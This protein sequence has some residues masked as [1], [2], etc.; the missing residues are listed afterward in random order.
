MPFWGVLFLCPTGLLG[1][2]TAF[3]LFRFFDI[4]KPPPAC[5][6]DKIKNGFGVMTDDVFAAAMRCWSGIAEVHSGVKMANS[7]QAPEELGCRPDRHP[8]LL[9]R[10]EILATA[11]S[12]TG[13][14]V[15]QVVTAIAGSSNWF[16]RGFV[17]YSNAAK[18]EMLG[19]SKKTLVRHGAVSEQGGYRNGHRS[20]AA[21]ARAQWRSPSGRRRPRPAANARKPGGHGL[22]RLGLARRVRR[23]VPDPPLPRPHCRRPKLPR[24]SVI[25]P[26]LGAAQ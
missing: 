6:F 25:S 10:G 16:D 15:S 8:Q 24:L 13:G 12:C 22:L 3:F 23:I 14:W 2:T 7:R 4:V 1:A 11:E 18:A 17:T 26:D 21:Q 19:V 9:E 5:N 20:A